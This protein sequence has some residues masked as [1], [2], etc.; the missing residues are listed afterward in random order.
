ML[1]THGLFLTCTQK[2]YLCTTHN[3]LFGSDP[4]RENDKRNPTYLEGRCFTHGGESPS[5]L[6]HCLVA[7][8]HSLL[9]NPPLTPSHPFSPHYVTMTTSTITVFFVRNSKKNGKLYFF[10]TFINDFFKVNFFN[11]FEL[12]AEEH[13]WSRQTFMSVQ[14]RPLA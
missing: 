3:Q 7:T 2:F 5:T 13:K 6:V 9:S 12:R 14:H 11:G 8:G 4:P 10:F 1:T